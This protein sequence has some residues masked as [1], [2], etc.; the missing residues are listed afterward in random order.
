MRNSGTGNPSSS[1]EKE[2]S[3]QRPH[4]RLLLK[5]I[6]APVRQA[7]LLHPFRLNES[8]VGD[9]TDECERGAEGGGH[10]GFAGDEAAE[11]GGGFAQDGAGCLGG[12]F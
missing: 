6:K 9:C 7:P 2:H 1:Q 10:E 3:A 4:S 11:G 5:V 12:D 8:V